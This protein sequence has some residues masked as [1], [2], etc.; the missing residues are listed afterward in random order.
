MEYM[1]KKEQ[2]SG[3]HKFAT[4]KLMSHVNKLG[5]QGWYLHQGVERYQNEMN[6]KEYSG[7]IGHKALYQINDDNYKLADLEGN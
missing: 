1:I 4:P 7:S 3:F 2:S 5:S 6:N